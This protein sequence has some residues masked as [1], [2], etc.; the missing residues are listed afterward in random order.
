MQEN[1]SSTDWRF[2]DASLMAFGAILEGPDAN[3]L[4]PLVDQAMP[5]LIAAMQDKSVVVKVYTI[6]FDRNVSNR[7]KP[8]HCIDSIV[9]RT[10]PLGR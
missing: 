6:V 7:H 9:H 2:R 10:R 5:M 1:I 3:A 4:R 8:K